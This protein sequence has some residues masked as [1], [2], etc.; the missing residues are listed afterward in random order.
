MAATKFPNVLYHYTS[1][2]GL[3]GILE[4]EKIWAS[5][6]H[7]LNDSSEFSY[8]VS[9]LR[10]YLWERLRRDNTLQTV[11]NR[12]RVE[13]ENSINMHIFVCSFTEKGDLLS[14]WRAYSGNSV[15]FS[16]GFKVKK[17]IELATKEGF[18]LHKC[19][20]N[21][22]EQIRIIEGYGCRILKELKSNDDLEFWG[23]HIA[24]FL[25][26]APLLKNRHFKE[27]AEWRLISRPKMSSSE[28]FKFR[29]SATTL[30]PYYSI[31][32][33]INE[34]ITQIIAGPNN[35][36][37]SLGALNTYFIKRK[38]KNI[39]LKSSEIPLRKV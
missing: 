14:Q 10:G 3:F 37:L 4:D 13:L 19:I 32:I 26:I 29:K 18:Y 20:Y 12:I 15:G 11:V 8:A 9:L 24:E 35:N 6:I 2:D 5:K 21:K 39:K 38:F 1:L 27:E 28:N 30:I 22:K 7:Y 31:P 17:L 23:Q 34:L 36:S 25:R 16:I 33:N